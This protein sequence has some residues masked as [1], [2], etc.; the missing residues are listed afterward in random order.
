MWS[1]T[2][3]ILVEHHLWI[4]MSTAFLLLLV[5]RKL[6]EDMKHAWNAHASSTC[7]HKAL[8]F[9]WKMLPS[10]WPRVW[11]IFSSFSWRNYS[12]ENLRCTYEYWQHP[13][14]K[15]L[16]LQ[17]LAY[18]H[19]WTSYSNWADTKP[20]SRVKQHS[21]GQKKTNYQTTLKCAGILFFTLP[22]LTDNRSGWDHKWRIIP[23]GEYSCSTSSTE[24]R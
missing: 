15:Y 23:T 6:S 22:G 3:W 5:L 19:W 13:C 17:Q 4:T 21:T 9:V 18:A 7:C 14:V 11:Q 10:L 16:F 24:S 2:L 8:L 20:H 12:A 1:I